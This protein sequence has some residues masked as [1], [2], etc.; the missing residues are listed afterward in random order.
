MIFQPYPTHIDL[1]GN[2]VC[3]IGNCPVCLL[4]DE[5]AQRLYGS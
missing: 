4:K 5:A 2:N 1:E 3:Q